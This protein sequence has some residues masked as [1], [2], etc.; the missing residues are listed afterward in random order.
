MGERSLFG[1]ITELYKRRKDLQKKMSGATSGKKPS[2]SSKQ[3]MQNEVKK[4]DDLL[5]EALVEKFEEGRP[6]KMD[7]YLKLR[8]D[9]KDKHPIEED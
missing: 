8:K 4:I 7:K 6:D 1:F 9:I 2:V 3:I 5:L